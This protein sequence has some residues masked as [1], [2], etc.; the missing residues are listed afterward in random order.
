[1]RHESTIVSAR[2]RF[3]RVAI[4]SVLALTVGGAVAAHAAVAPAA[5][6]V[7]ATPGVLSAAVSWNVNRPPAQVSGVKCRLTSPSGAVSDPGC[8]DQTST[9]S[10]TTWALSLGGLGVGTYTFAATATLAD[11]SH[12]DGSAA[13]TIK[14]L[15]ATCTVSGYS[16]SFDGNEHAATGSCTGLAGVP[17]SGSY[18][19]LSASAHTDVGVYKDAWAFTDPT[20]TYAPLTGTVRGAIQRAEQS[21]AFGAG[22]GALVPG[23]TYTPD[24]SA[25][26]GLP[27]NLTIASTSR[28]I[29]SL[30]GSV[31]S[32]T[33]EGDCTM[34]A[35]QAGDANWGP[36]LRVEKTLTIQPAAPCTSGLSASVP[37]Q[38][39]ARDGQTFYGNP[40]P[41]PSSVPWWGLPVPPGLT[42]VV[43]RGHDIEL[44]ASLTGG[45]ADAAAWTY[46]WSYGLGDD[47][48]AAV[49][50]SWT[51]AT[52]ASLTVPR[53]SLLFSDETHKDY[54]FTVTATP[55]GGS[56][57]GPLTASV[58]LRVGS[59]P[60]DRPTAGFAPTG[61]TAPLVP[62]GYTYRA[63]GQNPFS[64][65]VDSPPDQQDKIGYIW[66]AEVFGGDEIPP[67]FGQ[68]T[69]IVHYTWTSLETFLIKL[70]VCSANAPTSPT[71]PC[72][73]T[74]DFIFSTTIG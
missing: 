17:L 51:G 30:N 4:A 16:V 58:M 64:F 33:S 61:F 12:A 20:G 32:L 63:L 73:D 74:N 49:P 31:V 62:D 45:C 37:A 25:T 18:L 13:F 22:S 9:S 35:K 56:S 10:K 67:D 3:A 46:S 66:Y 1:M 59:F 44:D 21:V 11:G 60:A 27:V 5:V 14:P 70:T 8:G 34:V 23:G 42:A 38:D 29:C 71:N 41:A 52:A 69:P 47:T 15:K 36:A 26:S 39:G 2:Q 54:T 57:Q 6:T 43:S 68:G 7:Q 40:P 50:G 53:W 55:P 28:L 72:T 24:V 19:D 48:L 65:S